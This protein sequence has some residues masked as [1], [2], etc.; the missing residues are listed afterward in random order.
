MNKELLLIGNYR[1][2][3]RKSNEIRDMNISTDLIKD[4][5]GS[6]ELSFGETKVISWIN[7]PREGRGKS[8]E[9]KG[10][11]K[12]IFSLAPFAGMTRKKDYKRDLKMRDFSKSIKDIFEQIIILENYQKSEILINVLVT[13]IDGSYKAAAINAV[14]LALINSGIQIKDTLVSATL[15]LYENDICLYDVNL[16]E[17]K[18]K[19]PIFNVAY[20]PISKKFTYIELV[21]ANTPYENIEN[22][23]RE[24]E[25]ACGLVYNEIQIYLKEEYIKQ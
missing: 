19:I 12:C 1:S 11:V 15:G 20:L 23:M 9:N 13:Q 18:E 2:D 7:G 25:K 10:Q 6:A 22:L 24:A 14:T 4:A 8:M 17:E 5:N 3:G 16:Q 21:N